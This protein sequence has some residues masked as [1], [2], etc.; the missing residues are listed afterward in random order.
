MTRISAGKWDPDRIHQ[1]LDNL[2]MNAIKYGQPGVEISIALAQEGDE[3]VITVADNGP[4]IEAG[5]KEEIFAA[6]YRTPSARIGQVQG[7]GLGLYICQALVEAHN[8]RIELLAEA[9]KGSTFVIRLPATPAV[10]PDPAESPD[11]AAAL[12][13]VPLLDGEIPVD[14]AE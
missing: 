1:V 8:G 10:Q 11:A 3:A 12:L 14:A 13:P 9:D 7:L 5:Q 4:G 6:F 2:I